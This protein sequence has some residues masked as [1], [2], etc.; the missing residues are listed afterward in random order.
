MKARMFGKPRLHIGMF[1]RG[2]VIT[3]E[4]QR[5]VL[6]CFPI[7]LAEKREPLRVAVALL[8]LADN[9]AV[10]HAECGKERGGAVAFI[11]MG[12]GA[13]AALFDGQ[14]RLGPIQRPAH[15]IATSPPHFR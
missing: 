14:S 4:M 10:K 11:V 5:F 3:D 7:D 13:R 6:W 12:R 2:V 9:L 15:V 8:A 1:M